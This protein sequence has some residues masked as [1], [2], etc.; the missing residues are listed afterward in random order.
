VDKLQTA[1]GTAVLGRK[2]SPWNIFVELKLTEYCICGQLFLGKAQQG[3][4]KMLS[5]RLLATKKNYA[6]HRNPTAGIAP[7]K[8]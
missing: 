2:C 7:L 8:P 6:S 4:D 3:V 1:D 5:A